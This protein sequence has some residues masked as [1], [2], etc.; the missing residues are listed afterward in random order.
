VT[1]GGRL[2]HVAAEVVP[3]GQDEHEVEHRRDDRRD[4]QVVDAGS[5]SHGNGQKDIYHVAGIPQCGAETDRRHDA[6]KAE[7]ERKAVLHHHDDARHHNRQEDQGLRHLLVVS[8]VAGLGGHV[9]PGDR[10]HQEQRP[11]KHAQGA[12]RQLDAF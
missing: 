3:P 11:E 8:L 7:G 1:S 2:Q 12:D 10:Q 9:H 6:R 5:E 4:D